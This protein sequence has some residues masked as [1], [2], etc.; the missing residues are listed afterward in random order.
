MLYWDLDKWML[1]ICW[2]T[3]HWQRSAQL[4]PHAG[5]IPVPG[6][7]WSTLNSEGVIGGAAQQ[8]QVD[9]FCTGCI[10]KGASCT[11]G[12]A[13]APPPQF[14]VIALFLYLALSYSHFSGMER[15][16]HHYCSSYHA[17]YHST[18]IN[19]DGQWSHT[20]DRDL[21]KK[22]KRRMRLIQLSLQD[23]FGAVLL[24]LSLFVYLL[25]ESKLPFPWMCFLPV[26]ISISVISEYFYH[27]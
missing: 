19:I 13:V 7:S 2:K 9:I 16:S 10:T 26:F 14:V 5:W 6:S 12:R 21:E 27:M 24:Y 17:H 23:P 25:L 4:L 15:A 11:P 20:C 18:A 22:C 3:A 1:N 8:Q